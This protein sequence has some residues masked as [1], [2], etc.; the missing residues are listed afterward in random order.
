[1]A[2]VLDVAADLL[3]AEVAEVSLHTADPGDTG[4]SEYAG[5]GYARQIPLYDPASGGVA[6]LAAPLQ[7]DGDANTGPITHVGL[8]QTGSTFLHGVAVDTAESFN[9][10]GRLDMASLPISQAFPV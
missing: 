9:S 8:W 7:F 10:D 3:A 4:A 5:A 1:M 6:D 2:H